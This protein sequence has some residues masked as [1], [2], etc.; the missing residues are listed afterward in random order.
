MIACSC[1]FLSSANLETAVRE[2]AEQISGARSFAAAAG[3]VFRATH[4]DT[5]NTCQT[6]MPHIGQAIVAEGVRPQEEFDHWKRRLADARGTDCATCPKAHA[7]T[8]SFGC[9]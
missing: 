9:K 1:A 7:C 8:V 2:N 4:Q 6:C 3:I 5:R